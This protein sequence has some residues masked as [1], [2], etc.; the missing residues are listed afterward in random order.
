MNRIQRRLVVIFFIAVIAALGWLWVDTTLTEA[1]AG[2]ARTPVS[3]S[4]VAR[5]S[6]VGAGAPGVGATPGRGAG[7][8]GVG[9]TPGV[10]AGAPGAGATR[11]AGAGAR[12]AGVTP[13]P[14][15]GANAGGPVNRVG[16]R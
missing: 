5:R 9:A 16:A 4:G 11:G 15:V 3:Y 6:T 7:A 14:G 2:A 1:R 8:P 10:G 13:S 12:G